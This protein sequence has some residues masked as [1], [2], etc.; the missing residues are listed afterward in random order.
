MLLVLNVPEGDECA[1]CA[2]HYVKCETNYCRGID[3]P[4]CRIFDDVI[5]DGKKCEQCLR[6]AT[7]IGPA[8][9]YRG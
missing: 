4:R 3:I 6:H 9:L 8:P 2:F 1:S 5:K 7:S